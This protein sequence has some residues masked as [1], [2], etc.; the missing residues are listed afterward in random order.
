MSDTVAETVVRQFSAAASGYANSAVHANGPDLPGFARAAGAGPGDVALDI[1]TGAGHAAFTLAKEAKHVTGI[2]I[3]EN[4]LTFANQNA[5]DRGVANVDF[6]VGDALALDFEADSFDIV[7][8]RVSA[9]HFS[10]PQRA[11]AEM[12]R[13]LKPGG[14]VVIVDTISPEDPA[15]DTFENAIELLRDASHVRNYRASEWLEMFGSAGLRAEVV[16]RSGYVLDGQ[17]WVQRMNTPATK[18]AMIR[19]L[20]AEAS[21][22]LRSYFELREEPWSWTLP[23]AIFRAVAA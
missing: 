14:R 20:F 12:A 19:E 9:H 8:C 5:K 18:V 11:V 3:T 15:L 4:M 17:S 10:A 22:S 23:Y 2:D 16:E 1:A 7:T 6:R 13:V 21:P